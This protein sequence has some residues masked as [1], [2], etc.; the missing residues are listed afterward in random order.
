M[1]TSS[2]STFFQSKEEAEAS[3]AWLLIDAENQTLG[4]LS[5]KIA[6]YLR[7]KHKPTYT[8]HVDGGD[9]VVVINAEKVRLTGDKL[10]KKIYYK[11]TGY[12]GGMKETVAADMLEKHPTRLIEEAVKGMLPKGPLGKSMAKKLKIFT[13]SNHNHG[14]Q[15][16]QLLKLEDIN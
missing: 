6:H 13:G 16:P 12:M 14:A 8:S 2:Q 9:F 3:R 5:S 1:S 7:G 4:R 11:H 10:N 15:K